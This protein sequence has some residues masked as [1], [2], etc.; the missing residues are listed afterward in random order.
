MTSPISP[1]LAGMRKPLIWQTRA[2]PT[3][4][5]CH[6][7]IFE[8]RT[9][10]YHSLPRTFTSSKTSVPS[11]HFPWHLIFSPHS[12]GTQHPLEGANILTSGVL[13]HQLLKFSSTT[14][15]IIRQHGDEIR[16]TF[17]SMNFRMR[18]VFQTW[19]CPLLAIWFVAKY[20][21]IV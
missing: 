15:N 5:L 4:W 18:S 10:F 17:I 6:L 9:S 21:F 14:T 19:L 7:F 20:N 12:W 13:S 2:T 8:I 1:H 3:L 16:T 11:S